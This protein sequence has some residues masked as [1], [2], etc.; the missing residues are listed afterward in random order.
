MALNYLVTCKINVNAK[1]SPG[2]RRFGIWGKPQRPKEYFSRI[3]L[4]G[5][6]AF[7]NFVDN[8]C[9]SCTWMVGASLDAVCR[10]YN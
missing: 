6:M 2:N 4:F 5:N 8:S 7:F 1:E 3:P 10:W 9:R